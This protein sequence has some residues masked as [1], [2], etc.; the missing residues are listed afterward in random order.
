LAPPASARARPDSGPSGRRTRLG[1]VP[2]RASWRLGLVEA[3]PVRGGELLGVR[4][5]PGRSSREGHAAARPVL[6]AAAWQPSAVASSQWHR[7]RPTADHERS[8][9]A[10]RRSEV[11]EGSGSHRYDGLT[12]VDGL[13]IAC[14][15]RDP[16]R[17]DCTRRP[18][19]GEQHDP[20]AHHPAVGAD[21]HAAEN[22]F[23]RK[24]EAMGMGFNA[25]VLTTIR[26]TSGRERTAVASMGGRDPR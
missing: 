21:Q 18:T 25:P 20:E 17:R 7:S 13:G 5:P 1:R 9:T 24:G 15:R 14:L 22:R 16:S 6:V 4:A 26:Y 2:S 19:P 23:R 11:G 3:P 8:S 10:L 12:W